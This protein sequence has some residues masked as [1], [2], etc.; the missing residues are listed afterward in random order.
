MRRS[1]H[2]YPQSHRECYDVY[3]IHLDP[4]TE[5]GGSGI[6]ELYEPEVIE[7]SWIF[8]SID[9][10]D[11]GKLMLNVTTNSTLSTNSFYNVTVITAM[12]TRRIQFCKCLVIRESLTH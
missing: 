9:I 12:E 7:S 11:D 10:S 1:L 5:I 6:F 4:E 3:K 8:P 2:L